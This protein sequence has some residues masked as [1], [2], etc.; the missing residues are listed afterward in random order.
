MT[1]EDFNNYKF[2]SED[3]SSK[4]NLSD[5]DDSDY[6]GVS[7]DNEDDDDEEYD[8][9]EVSDDQE[10]N[11]VTDLNADY[12]RAAAEGKFKVENDDKSSSEVD[13]QQPRKKRSY[14][15]RKKQ[16]P[17]KVVRS[18][19]DGSV[20]TQEKFVSKLPFIFLLFVFALA[21]IMVRNSAESL[22]KKQIMLQG[23]VRELRA[24]S[25]TIAA[26]LMNISKETEVFARIESKGIPLKEQKET[27]KYFTVEKFKGDSDSVDVESDDDAHYEEEYNN[28]YN[29][30]E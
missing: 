14:V 18:F 1:I 19:L 26:K 6:N 17:G 23:E 11:D 13:A 22:I 4:K 28:I 3:T 27:P 24:E 29:T 15:R 8:I 12:E 16:T 2:E 5:D 9:E 30:G 21:Y 7:S 25:I 20:V 10:N